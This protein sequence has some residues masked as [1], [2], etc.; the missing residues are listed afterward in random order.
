MQHQNSRHLNVTTRILHED[1]HWHDVTDRVTYKLGVIMHRCQQGKSLRYFVDCCT[2][3]TDVVG[4]RRL[5]SATQQQY[6]W[7]FH[8]TGSPLLAA[9]HSLCMARWFGTLFLTTSAHSRTLAPSNRA[10]KLGYSLGTS[11]RNALETFAT[12]ALH[13]SMYTIPYQ[14]HTHEFV[15]VVA[16][17]CTIS[18]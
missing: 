17:D 6:W 11:V 4:R 8:E 16:I 5:R 14:Y 3:A 15:N 18:N 1:L 13:T 7:W 2:P 9:E 10:W 12:I